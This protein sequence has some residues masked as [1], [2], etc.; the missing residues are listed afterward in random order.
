MNKTIEQYNNVVKECQALFSKKMKDYGSAWRI[1][2][3]PSLTDQIFI[4]AQRIRGLQENSVHKIEEDETA[5][6]IGIV[7]YA[8]M[9]L[10]QIDRGIATQPDLDAEEATLLYEKEIAETR[11]L[12]ENKNHDYGEAWRDMRVSSLTDLI[13]QKILR[14]KQIE[15]NEGKTLVSE[16]IRANYQDML[17]Y[18]VFA[19]IHLGLA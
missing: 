18:A 17:N 2:R 12:M 9:A 11:T 10:I 13:L 1:L 15:D 14:V 7:N 6:F 19:L 8:V 5:E 16:G 4:K 3:L